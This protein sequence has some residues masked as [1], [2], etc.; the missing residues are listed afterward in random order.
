[1]NIYERSSNLALSND[2]VLDTD[3]EMLSDFSTLRVAFGFFFLF[4]RVWK[5]QEAMGCRLRPENMD[6]NIYGNFMQTLG[7]TSFDNVLDDS[8]N[9]LKKFLTSKDLE[10]F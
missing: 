6:M 9:C 4:E 5:C 3:E 7:R 8:K 1:V 2:G 10:L